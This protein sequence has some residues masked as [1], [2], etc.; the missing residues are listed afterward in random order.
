MEGRTIT[1]KSKIGTFTINQNEV[2]RFADSPLGYPQ[3]KD[4]VLIEEEDSIFIWLQSIEDTNIAFPMLEVE[5]LG[6]QKETFIGRDI[7][8]KLNTKKNDNLNV[9]SIIT[10]PGN[11][12]DMTAN[13]KAPVIIN[14]ENHIGMQ[15][16]LS[17]PDLEIAK[18]VF[19]ELKR[20]IASTVNT[21]TATTQSSIK[22]DPTKAPRI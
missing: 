12:Q 7:L 9:Y 20:R 2:I 10:I 13:F 1:V 15:T 19:V 8:E 3:L 11:V 5:L 14:S 17:N 22:K 4:F 6:L 18:P 21:D 16:I